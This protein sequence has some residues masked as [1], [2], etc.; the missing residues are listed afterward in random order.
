MVT[1]NIYAYVNNTDD[2]GPAVEDSSTVFHM[3]FHQ[4][5]LILNQFL[6]GLPHHL[7]HFAESYQ[8]MYSTEKISDIVQ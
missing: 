7:V 3:N 6:G 8:E 2:L 4:W 1:Q 5:M